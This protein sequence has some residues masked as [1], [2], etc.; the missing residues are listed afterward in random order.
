MLGY[1]ATTNFA[2]TLAALGAASARESTAIDWATDYKHDD[3]M[4][5]FRFGSSLG[6]TA[7]DKAV[8]VWFY[9]S[10]D[11]TNYTEP[12]TGSDAAITIGTN[13]NLFG[14]FVVALAAGQTNY[15]VCIPS[16]AQFFGGLLP[17]KWGVVVENQCNGALYNTEANYLKWLTPV[18]ITT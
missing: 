12:A 3:C 17:K 5:Q 11:G 14:P 7:A 9:G 4:L 18:F 1:A 8:Y 15:D 6:T 10:A 16:V 2:I 13:H